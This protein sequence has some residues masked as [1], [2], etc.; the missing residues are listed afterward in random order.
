MLIDT[1]AT[2]CGITIS[3]NDSYGEFLDANG[4]KTLT[5]DGA[6]INSKWLQLIKKLLPL[7]GN[8]LEWY[9]FAEHIWYF[10]W[11]ATVL[12]KIRILAQLFTMASSL[13]VISYAPYP[14]VPL[15]LGVL[16]WQKSCP[17]FHSVTDGNHPTLKHLADYTCLGCLGSLHTR[18]INEGASV[19]TQLPCHL[20]GLT[21]TSQKS[22]NRSWVGNVFITVWCYWWHFAGF[23]YLRVT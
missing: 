7:I 3:G 12:S 18:I 4:S 1:S 6:I 10:A 20:F 5:I 16:E 22:G 23:C 14:L 8:V 21:C 9:D 17:Q 13:L 15:F 19:V 11:S 2:N